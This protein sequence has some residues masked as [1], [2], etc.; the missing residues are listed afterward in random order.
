MIATWSYKI[1]WPLFFT[2]P[3][4]APLKDSKKAK[5]LGHYPSIEAWHVH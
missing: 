4:K 1:Q 3:F 5:K 2:K